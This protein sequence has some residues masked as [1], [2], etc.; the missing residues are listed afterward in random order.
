M[1]NYI[2]EKFCQEILLELERK[3]ITYTAFSDLCGISRKIMA[4]IVNRKKTD[5]KLST[6]LKICENSDIRLEDIFSIPTDCSIE[7]ALK[8]A[9]I[10]LEGKRYSIE[11]KKY[12]NHS[13]PP[14]QK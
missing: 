14:P 12:A 2:L 13:A 8:N 3:R 1:Q 9:Y 5:I 10:V 4:D 11:L 6:I 7:D